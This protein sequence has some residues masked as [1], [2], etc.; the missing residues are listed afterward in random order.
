MYLEC[1]ANKTCQ[2]IRCGVCKERK[3][4]K[5]SDFWPEQGGWSLLQGACG[6]GQG[7]GQKSALD[8]DV[9]SSGMY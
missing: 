5:E 7:G 3:K 8:E 2:W 9:L 4:E 1:G 6:V